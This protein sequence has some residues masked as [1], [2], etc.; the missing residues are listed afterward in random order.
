MFDLRRHPILREALVWSVPALIFGFVLRAM[1]ISYSPYAYWGSDSRSFLGFADGVIGQGYFSINEKR[2][3]LY[4]ILLLPIS[5]LPGGTLRW[6]GVLQPLL[7]LATVLPLAYVVRKAFV[8]WKAVIIPVT[9]LFA[10]MPV[11]LW[12]EH[13]LLA[14]TVMFDALVWMMGGWAAWATQSDARRARALWWWFL[15]SFAILLL[16]KPA[17][18]FLWPGMVLG[19]AATGGW[20]LLRWPQWTSLAAALG[21]SLTVGDGDQSAWLLYTTA[22]PLTNLESAAHAEIKDE[23][24]GLVLLKRANLG[25]YEEQDDEVHDLLRSPEDHR[26]FPKLRALAR[27]ERALSRT[28][29]ELAIEGILS[30]PLGFL[31][32]GVQRL[33]GSCNP[34]DFK[35]DRFEPGYFST[36]MA[37]QIEGG[38]NS[39]RMLRLAFGL[40]RNEPFPGPMD[41]AARLNPAPESA[42]ARWLPSYV[43]AW[44]AHADLISRPRGSQSHLAECRLTALGWAAVAG[45]LFS[46]IPALFRVVGVWTVTLAIYLLAVY[47]VGVE[48]TRYF[49]LAWA[50]IILLLA[51]L[52][53]AAWRLVQ[54]RRS[55]SSSSP[56][57]PRPMRRTAS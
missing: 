41:F 28:Y 45:G 16:T 26:E 13:E 9:V 4:P 17:G 35:T 40:G 5:L 19:L 24:R 34:G 37:A 10:G 48:H 14:D 46:L 25:T 53:E 33:T 12:Y 18:K 43:A 32:I 54:R 57:R 30:R 31:Q 29:N 44:F 47:L 51:V 6:L 7:G 23:L 22:F 15:V 20:R 55:L 38:R 50:Q 1:L 52:P 36:R 42:A 39:D 56:W 11:L 49:A 27:D 21:L 8:S 3:Y 2:R